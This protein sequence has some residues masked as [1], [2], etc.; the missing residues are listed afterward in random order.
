MFIHNLTFEVCDRKVAIESYITNFFQ[1]FDK[2]VL[3]HQL[4]KYKRIRI[5]L[6]LESL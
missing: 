5:S 4:I 1:M 6:F 3:R 2:Y